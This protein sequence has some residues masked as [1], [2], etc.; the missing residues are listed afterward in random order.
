MPDASELREVDF[1][2]SMRL[3]LTSRNYN[4]ASGTQIVSVQLGGRQCCRLTLSVT[5]TRGQRTEMSNIFRRGI[6]G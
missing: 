3:D 6:D 4:T 2:M 5:L 1:G